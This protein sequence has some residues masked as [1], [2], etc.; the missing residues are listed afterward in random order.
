[1]AVVELTPSLGMDDDLDSTPSPTS[2]LGTCRNL[3]ADGQPCTSFLDCQ[4]S[5]CGDQQICI[6]A[7]SKKVGE[8]CYSSE[9]S[10]EC[11]VDA[12]CLSNHQEGPKYCRKLFT[13]PPADCANGNIPSPACKI[14]DETYVKASI[15][16]KPCSV[17]YEVSKGSPLASTSNSRTLEISQSD[18]CTGHFTGNKLLW[19]CSNCTGT[20]QKYDTDAPLIAGCIEMGFKELYSN[21]QLLYS[22]LLADRTKMW[23]SYPVFEA[24]LARINARTVPKIFC[25]IKADSRA[26]N[27]TLGSYPGAPSMGSF[28]DDLDCAAADQQSK[29]FSVTLNGE[30]TDWA[31]TS[32]SGKLRREKFCLQVSNVV[33]VDPSLCRIH[34][35]ASGSVVVDWYYD[36][37]TPTEAERVT[38]ETQTRFVSDI[39]PAL[40]PVGGVANPTLTVSEPPSDGSSFL[41]DLAQGALIAIIVCIVGGCILI[42]LCIL[43]IVVICCCC[44]SK[45]RVETTVHKKETKTVKQSKTI[46]E[47]DHSGHGHK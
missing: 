21:V 24:R 4:S 25:C 1:M 23:T 15:L 38:N 18:N 12:F 33:N 44:C 31:E 32:A 36:G 2:G 7:R 10:N 26:R 19:G 16:D 40:E 43:L 13:L 45:P 29:L 41:N 35:V 9:F 47:E 46:E 30:I 27:W 5:I 6:A 14:W 17:S 3:L 39:I 20:C 28:L 42:W 8:R 11:E 37:L 22:S 34:R